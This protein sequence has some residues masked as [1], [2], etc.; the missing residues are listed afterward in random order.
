MGLRTPLPHLLRQLLASLSRLLRLL[1]A[2]FRIE[3]LHALG[4]RVSTNL[5]A[6]VRAGLLQILQV[7]GGCRRA[8]RNKDRYCQEPWNAHLL[9]LMYL[10][11]GC[12]IDA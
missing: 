8:R 2:N 5:E 9:L 3:P 6:V 10:A 1:L 12:G 7:L 11:A 4:V